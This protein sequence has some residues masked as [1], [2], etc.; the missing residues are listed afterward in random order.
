MKSSLPLIPFNRPTLAGPELKYIS[1]AISAGHISGNGFFTHKAETL[2]AQISGS[3]IAL[4]TTSCTHALELSAHILRLGPGDEVIVPAY[5]FV[6]TASAFALTG[7]RPIFVDVDPLTLNLSLD[8]LER[9]ISPRTRAVC[10]VHYAGIA[11]ELDKLVEFCS[12]R[13]IPL[14][15]DNAHGLGGSFG[16]KNLGTFGHMSTLSFHET[17]NVTC[18]EGGALAINDDSVVALAEILREKGTDRAKFLRGQVDKYTWVEVG[19]SWVASDILAAFLVAQ[20]EGFSQSQENRQN[21]WKSYD[22]TLKPWAY[23]TGVLTPSVPEEASH[24]AHMYYLRFQS[25]DQR[26]AFINHMKLNGVM[27]VFHY[28]SLN[29]SAVGKRYGGRPGDCP[30]SEQAADT[31]VRLPLF[32]DLSSTE[33]DRVIGAVL[34]FTEF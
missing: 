29:C 2:L 25:L 8:S 31:L 10:T 13:G 23:K 20:L 33:L 32:S 3:P 26:S 16:G 17:K 24:P 15:E 27:T 19:S 22:E 18:G 14:I 7:A 34:A 12:S 28:Q 5:T 21:I 9:A 11:N 1:E 30:V 6:S 4:L